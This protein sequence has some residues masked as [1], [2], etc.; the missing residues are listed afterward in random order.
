VRATPT[1]CGL[2]CVTRHANSN[3]Q[4]LLFAFFDDHYRLL[5]GYRWGYAEDTVHLDAA[6]RPAAGFSRCPEGDLRE[7]RLGV[8][9]CVAIA[10][11]REIRC[12]P[13][14]F[15]AMPA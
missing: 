15:D 1:T 8:L 6:L 5:P 9:G 3:P 12:A 11:V 10:S 7:S 4:D 14:A 13:N 2:E